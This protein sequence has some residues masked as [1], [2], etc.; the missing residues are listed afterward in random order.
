MR[1]YFKLRKL[2]AALF[3][4]LFLATA[5]HPLTVEGKDTDEQAPT[6]TELLK[7]YRDIRRR[8]RTL[9]FLSLG[10]ILLAAAG[11]VSYAIYL[12]K[13]S[14]S[15]PGGEPETYSPL[16][17]STREEC[18]RHIEEL[19]LKGLK[20]LASSAD[21]KEC[22]TRITEVAG[23]KNSFT[24]EL[25]TIPASPGDVVRFDYT[26]DGIPYTFSSKVLDRGEGGRV[27]LE[28]PLFIKYTQRRK[29]LRSA[30]SPLEHAVVVTEDGKI[31]RINDISPGGFSLLLD[32]TAPAPES[33][34]FAIQLPGK[35]QWKVSARRVYQVNV[36]R[37]N[38]IQVRTGWSF[39]DPPAGFLKDL[40]DY[41]SRTGSRTK[42]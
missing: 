34:Q 18:A 23:G 30:P 40:R 22:R 9:E 16:E 28:V 19:K 32:Q 7:N 5:G 36:S 20:L 35:K 29:E 38:R 17:L 37:G 41:L 27:R 26:F 39:S 21:G 1:K 8:Y 11:A 12:K 14:G 6:Y 15:E 25:L 24:L 42:E 13:R 10:I 31:F 3:L 33:S 4:L 2:T